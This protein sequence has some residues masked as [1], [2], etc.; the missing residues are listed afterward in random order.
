MAALLAGSGQVVGDFSTGGPCASTL[1]DR[2]AGQHGR[3]CPRP[4]G[5][6]GPSA[7]L[8]VERTGFARTERKSGGDTRAKVLGTGS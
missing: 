5:A 7:L 8:T 3:G 6:D 4:A 1:Q 2:A